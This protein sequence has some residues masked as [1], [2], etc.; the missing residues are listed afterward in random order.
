MAAAR[1]HPCTGLHAP[2]ASCAACRGALATPAWRDEF[3]RVCFCGS[4]LTQVVTPVRWGLCP[5]C[6]ET[7]DGE[8]GRKK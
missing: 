1:L 8:R 2:G 3:V 6:G 4:R 5:R 7:L